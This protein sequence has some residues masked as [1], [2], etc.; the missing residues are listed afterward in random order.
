MCAAICPGEGEKFYPHSS[1]EEGLSP[2]ARKKEKF[3][4]HLNVYGRETQ[5]SR[6]RP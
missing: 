6:F 2:G 3:F 4:I 5:V 1:T